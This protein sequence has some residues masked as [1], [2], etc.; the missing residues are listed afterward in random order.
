MTKTQPA[1]THKTPLRPTGSV[2]ISDKEWKVG[3]QSF[4]TIDY[5]KSV[6][7]RLTRWKWSSLSGIA[8]SGEQI[9]INL[10]SPDRFL[11]CENV[12]WVNGKAYS[13][14]KEN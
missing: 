9:T 2:F 4:S 1:Y 14:F 5:T 12:I 10:T 3:G 6:E 8:K 7:L 11:D 13:W